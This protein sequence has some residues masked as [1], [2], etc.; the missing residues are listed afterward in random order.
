MV[1][2]AARGERAAGHESEGGAGSAA[3]QFGHRTAAAM[4]SDRRTG[5]KGAAPAFVVQ[6]LQLRARL[7]LFSEL[8]GLTAASRGRL[9]ERC[10]ADERQWEE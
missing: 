5:A 2:T 3:A 1:R 6:Y 7:G 10:Q 4:T 9:T 8:K